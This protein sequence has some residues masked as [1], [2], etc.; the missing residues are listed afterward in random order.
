[1]FF[2][3]SSAVVRITLAM[4]LSLLVNCSSAPDEQSFQQPNVILVMTDDQGWA[5]VG[6]HGNQLLETPNLDRLA[7]QSVEMTRFYVSPVCAPTRASLMTG[8]YNYRTGVVDTYLGRAMMHSDEVTLAE[9]LGDVG[10]RNGIFGK[11]HLGDNYP[12]RATDQGFHEVLIHKGGGIGQ[13]SDPLD[14]SYFD[15]ILQQN[16]REEKFQGYCTDI[17]FDAARRFIELNRDQP[18]FA[19]ISTNAPH[20]PYDVP[21][22]YSSHYKK[23]G[24]NDKD[25]RIYGMITNIDENVGLLLNTLDELQLAENTI[26]IFM[27]D[28]GATTQHYTA[29]LR[30][31]KTSVYDGGIR[32][33]FFLRWPNRFEP[34]K[35]D[36][37]GAHID[38]LPTILDAVEVNIP[39]KL[40]IDGQSLLPVFTGDFP[41]SERAIFIQ[42]HRGN[43]PTLYRNFAVVEQQYKLLQPLHFSRA[44]PK[45]VSFELYDLGVDPGERND[46]ASK[47]PEVVNRMR[48]SYETWFRDVSSTRGY[49]PLHISVGTE[50]ENPVVLTRQDWRVVGPDGWSDSHLGYWS[51]DVETGGTYDIRFRFTKQE[52]AGRAE[53]ELGKIKLTRPFTRHAES[54]SF[55]NLELGPGMATLEA[56]LMRQG[57]AVGVKYVDVLRTE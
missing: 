50:E 35:I 1:M 39:E 17:F 55:S 22:S 38:V 37:V 7:S 51:I 47:M 9:L 31:Q 46:L 12:M 30:A 54:V 11:W 21:E 2:L 56:R 32:V 29:G 24:L 26:L 40:M 27:T 44:A 41:P 20:S 15:P 48:F 8:R 42:S 57:K 53:F 52:R 36:T 13:P 28:N 14:T 16:N 33:P 43:E 6:S 5:Q 23:K 19:Y 34:A 4:I 3:G 10:Y 25:A 18:F 49:S 45:K